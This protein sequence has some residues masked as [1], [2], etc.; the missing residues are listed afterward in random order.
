MSTEEIKDD[1]A[2]LLRLLREVSL[3]VSRVPETDLA[4]V[5][6]RILEGVRSVTGLLHGKVALFD[7]VSDDLYLLTVDGDAGRA[8]FVR[9]KTQGSGA[10]SS[11]RDAK[12]LN[13][14][15]RSSF[16]RSEA[17]QVIVQ[18][19]VAGGAQLGELRVASEQG[20]IAPGRE[21]EELLACL[22]SLAGVALRQCMPQRDPL[23]LR[24]WLDAFSEVFAASI[25]SGAR[26]VDPL[27]Q[28]IVDNAWTISRSDFVVLYEYFQ[29]RGDVRLPPKLAGPIWDEEVLR[30]RG[31]AM[32]HRRS[33]V[34]HLLEQ[35]LPFYA[36]EATKDWATAGLLERGGGGRPFFVREGV[37]SSAGIPLRS[38]GE[39]VGVLFINYRRK[40]IFSP[41]FREHLELFANQAALAIGNARFFLR[42]ER[43]SRD[44]EA[45]NRIGRELGSYVA[46]DI[47]QIGQLIFEK[48]QEVIPTRNF[49]LCVYNAEGERYLLPFIRDQHDTRETLEPRLRLGL[50]GYV[51]RTRK[52]LLATK[53]KIGDLIA[54]GSA[55]MVGRPAAVWLGAPLVA[56]DEVIGALVVQDYAEE[57][58]FNRDHLSLLEA[59]AS[60]A[61][62]AIDNYRLLNDANLQ[63]KELSALL[64]LS[65]AF[66]ASRVNTTELL[67]SILD[68]LCEVAH[69][70]GSLLLLFESGGRERLKIMAA[71]RSLVTYLGESV[72]VGEGVSGR[73]VRSGE[74]MIVNDYADWEGRSKL[75]DPPPRCVCGAP[76]IWQDEV[77]GAISLSSNQENASFSR[78]ETEILRRFAGPAA[79]FIQRTA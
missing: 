76:L 75:F 57:A 61:A 37:L 20:P 48:A 22:A 49:F 51:C 15:E 45:L 2:V 32:D 73:I 35:Q 54:D 78:R 70:D 12:P 56:R 74:P 40:F 53:D 69:C 41:D 72:P 29:E 38:G 67:S 55:E 50:T 19:I 62:I 71:A 65:R 16:L 10:S 28:E 21:R 68:Q 47:E 34:F 5:M 23:Q 63:V 30:G 44:L 77:V 3:D 39:A 4:E 60:Q 11:P 64:E 24:E 52:T 33:A 59:I 17:N 36:E 7:D 25:P 8:S 58:M 9:R 27:L 42:A 46:R 14:Q 1:P 79:I 18:P 43:Y 6:R 13:P 31:V 26:E 66:G